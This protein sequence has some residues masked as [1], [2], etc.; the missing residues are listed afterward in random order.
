MYST[1]HPNKCI[2]K[3]DMNTTYAAIHSIMVHTLLDANQPFL[4]KKD[5]QKK[6]GMSLT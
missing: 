4:F 2:S 6:S 5:V 1:G 3:I